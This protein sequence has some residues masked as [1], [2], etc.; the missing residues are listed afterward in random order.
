MTFIGNATRFVRDG[1]YSAGSTA[2]NGLARLAG[3]GQA[4]ADANATGRTFRPIPSRPSTPTDFP[5]AERDRTAEL[6]QI[7]KPAL[8]R[9]HSV[10][11]DAMHEAANRTDAAG[12]RTL[13][14]AKVQLRKLREDPTKTTK[15]VHFTVDFGTTIENGREVEHKIKLPYRL[16]HNGFVAS[17]KLKEFKS[18]ANQ[19]RLVLQALY[20]QINDDD[21][22]NAVKKHTKLSI[23]RDLKHYE[24]STTENTAG[25]LQ[26]KVRVES[27]KGRVIEHTFKEDILVKDQDE[28]KTVALEPYIKNI[29]QIVHIAAK[30]VKGYAKL[31]G[32]EFFRNMIAACGFAEHALSRPGPKMPGNMSHPVSPL[33]DDP[34]RLRSIIDNDRDMQRQQMMR[35]R[36]NQQLMHDLQ[37]QQGQLGSL[38]NNSAFQP[39]S[40]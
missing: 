39:I 30:E 25:E 19:T 37:R 21:N 6:N 33:N 26:L 28:E 3:Y 11:A 16:R 9:S 36:Q 40:S 35:D 13:E 15:Q 12:R 22:L 14:E 20:S 7:R 29:T 24:I 34:N 10:P 4:Q 27:S 2:M 18:L 5:A 23:L 32:F 31:S 1:L 17:G 8:Q 38:G